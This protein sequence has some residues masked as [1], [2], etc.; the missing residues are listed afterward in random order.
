MTASATQT[1]IPTPPPK[2]QKMTT[3]DL[4][5]R[6]YGHYGGQLDPAGHRGIDTE[7]DL[8][9]E[10]VAAP[11][12]NRRIDLLRIGMWA[13]RGHQII[14]HELKVSRSDWLRELED[15]A[16]ADAWWPYC[17]QLWIVA[18][19]GVV[20][21]DELPS[22]WGLMNPPTGTRTRTRKFK[23]IVAASTKE[24]VVNT[25]LLV[26]VVRRVDNRRLSQIAQLNGETDNAVHNAVRNDRARRQAVDLPPE[27]QHRINQLAKLESALGFELDSWD[28]TGGRGP[29]SAE[30]GEALADYIRGHVELQRRAADLN[31]RAEALRS[32]ARLLLDRIPDPNKEIS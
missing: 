17:H 26:E 30:V 12:S 2:P 9:I 3:S 8:L 14:A 13:S 29:R 22:G 5:K 32:A 11:S 24:P 28:G 25:A 20:T 4:L 23:T 16:K 19:Q 7:S 6:L 31:H 21:P 1:S 15:P 18:P 27:L 10:E